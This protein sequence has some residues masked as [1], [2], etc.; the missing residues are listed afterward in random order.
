ML[1]RGPNLSPLPKKRLGEGLVSHPPSPRMDFTTSGWFWE[2]Q[3]ISG[4]IP[5]L[6]DPS[7][8]LQVL[9]PRDAVGFGNHPVP[10]PAPHPSPPN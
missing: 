4:S 9:S 5:N 2:G 8:S 3:R 7:L 10:F 6:R 1:K